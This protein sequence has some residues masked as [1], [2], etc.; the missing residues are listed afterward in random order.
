[1]SLQQLPAKT[2]ADHPVV[3]VKDVPRTVSEI[4]KPATRHSI[5]FS[6]RATHGL[7]ALTRRQPA[8]RIDH[9]A[10]TLRAREAKLASKRIPKKI[11]TLLAAVND[12]RLVRM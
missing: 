7:A 1:M 3:L 5:Q 2:F 9:L 4:G 11:K 12:V 8:N 6:K 10:V